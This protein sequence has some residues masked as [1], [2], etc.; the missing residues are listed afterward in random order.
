V[1]AVAEIA[2]AIADA[3]AD[4]DPIRHRGSGHMAADAQAVDRTHV[5]PAIGFI[6]GREVRRHHRP[7]EL[8]QVD[9]MPAPD[10]P[11]ELL[12]GFHL[13]RLDHERS[14]PNKRTIVNS[15]LTS[16]SL[17][18]APFSLPALP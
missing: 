9:L 1:G 6:R 3:I 7:F 5:A 16:R 18:Y 13:Q 10:E 12:L 4:L 11:V 15:S 17:P 2:D 8:R 14:L